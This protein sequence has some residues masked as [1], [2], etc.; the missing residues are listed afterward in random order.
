MADRKLI[1]L[2]NGRITARGM[3]FADGWHYLWMHE[4]D[5]LKVT[6]DWNDWLGTDTISTSTFTSDGTAGINTSSST[7]TEA[8]VTLAGEDGLSEIEN[9]ITTA[10][11]LTKV[12]RFRT[13]NR[14]KAVEDYPTR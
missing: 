3:P 13:R 8:T 5:V 2:E 11:G 4:D 12:L 1:V 10:N 9:K 14:E 6:V 7:T